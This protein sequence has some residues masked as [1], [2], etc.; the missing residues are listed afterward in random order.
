MDD[1]TVVHILAGAMLMT[2]KLAGPILAVCLIVGLV[3]AVLQTIS[4]IQEMTLSFVPKLVGVGIV[5]IVG[6]PWMIHQFT[7]WVQDLWR[8][9]PTL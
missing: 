1:T 8:M 5:L 2:L 9:I 7:G 4:Q 3:V 6:G